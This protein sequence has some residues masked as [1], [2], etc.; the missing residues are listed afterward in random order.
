MNASGPTR[1]RRGA[2]PHQSAA[3]RR[4]ALPADV[5]EWL[6]PIIAV[7]P[8]QVLAMRLAVVRGGEINAPAG[9]TKVTETY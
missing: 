9:L 7:V 5:P 2:D 1:A 8:G 3:E 4:S 6:S